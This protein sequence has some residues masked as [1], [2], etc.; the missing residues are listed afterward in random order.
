MPSKSNERFLRADRRNQ[1]EKGRLERVLKLYEKEKLHKALEIDREKKEFVKSLSSVR[2]TSG[3]SD[4][5]VAPTG[6][7]DNDYLSAPVYRMG[8]RL[9]ERRLMGWRAQE[10]EEIKRILFKYQIS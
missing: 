8:I 4:Q 10:K 2:R 1:I 5:G 3:V 9:S 7:S 6:K